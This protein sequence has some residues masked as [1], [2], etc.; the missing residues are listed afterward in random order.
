VVRA[1]AEKLATTV[2]NV[3]QV[4]NDLQVREQKATSSN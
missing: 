2:P 4:V 3:T 1:Q